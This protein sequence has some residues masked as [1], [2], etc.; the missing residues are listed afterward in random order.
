MGDH[1]I[2]L[3]MRLEVGVVFGNDCEFY[4]FAISAQGYRAA[5]NDL[6]MERP[7]QLAA[8]VQRIGYA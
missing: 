1:S 5:A 8:P 2:R 6:A 7:A 3:D 4:F